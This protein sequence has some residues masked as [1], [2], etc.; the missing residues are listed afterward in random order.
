MEA[1]PIERRLAAILSADVEGYSRPMHG[2]EEATLAT[3]S[4]HRAGA[5]IQE[6]LVFNLRTALLLVPAGQR[7]SACQIDTG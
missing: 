4:A 5:A 7:S 6:G 2:D 3:L 1:P